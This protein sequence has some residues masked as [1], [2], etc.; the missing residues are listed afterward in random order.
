MA[1]GDPSPDNALD[2]TLAISDG[3]APQMIAASVAAPATASAAIASAD[4]T[5]SGWEKFASEADFEAWLI[6]TAIAQ[7]GHLF[8][9]QYGGWYPYR[10]PITRLR[11][12]K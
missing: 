9:Q 3:G 4:A 1:A 11:M 10:A 7:Y 8:G 12:C 2:A 6:E 5:D